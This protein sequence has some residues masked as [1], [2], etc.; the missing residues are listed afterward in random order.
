MEGRVNGKR[1]RRGAFTGVDDLSEEEE[2]EDF[3]MESSAREPKGDTFI[4]LQQRAD[5][6]EY[7]DK[8]QSIATREVQNVQVVSDV[9]SA[10]RRNADSSI[11]AP[12]IVKRKPKGSRV[13]PYNCSY[14]R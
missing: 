8:T 2:D 4:E 13:R 3:S 14:I 11:Q 5:T 7:P 12:K 10:L 1:R 6:E 9:G